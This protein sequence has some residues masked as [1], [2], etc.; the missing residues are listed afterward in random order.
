MRIDSAILSNA[1]ITA[2]S[3]NPIVSGSS[4]VN[5]TNTTG[6]STFS[7]SI[8]TYTDAKVAGLVDSAPGTLN[9]LNELAAALGDDANMSAS[10]ATTLGTKLPTATHTAFSSSN[11]SALRTEYSGA[12]TTLS[13]SAHSDRVAKINVLSGSAHTQR[14]AIDAKIS[15][16][17][18]TYATDASVSS[19][20]ASAHTRREQIS[21]SL[22]STIDG[23]DALGIST[24]TERGALSSSAHTQREAIKGLA[25]T[26]NNSLSSST[27]A[28]LRTEYKAGDTAL[29]ASA[30]TRRNELHALQLLSSSVGATINDNAVKLSGIESGATADQSNAEIRAAVEAAS[31]SNVFTDADHSK[32]NAIEASADVTDATNVA[33]AG[34]LMSSSLGGTINDNVVKLAGIEAGATADQTD[35]EIQDIVGAMLTGNTES[36]ITVTYQDGDGTIDFSVASQTDQNF[37]NADH[38]KLDGIEAGADVTDTTNVT[39]AGALMDSELTS[40]ADVKALDQSVIS[41]ADPTFGT[42]NMTDATNKRFMTDAQE[43]KLDSVETNADVT[44]ATNV[45]AAGALMDSEVTNLAAVKAIN[46]GLTTTSDVTFADIL[47]TGNLTVQGTRT[48]L[49]VATLNVEDLNITVASGSADSAA[50]DGAGITIAGADESLTWDHG[51]SRFNFSDDV[52]VVGNITVSGNVDGR[53]IA[54]DGTKLDG[55]EASADVTDATNVTAAGALMDSELTSIA[56]VKA[57]DQSVVA[58]A[59]PDFGTA[60]MSDASNKRFMTDAQET[61]LDGIEASADVTDATNVAAAGALMSSSLGATINDNAVKLSGIEAGATQDQT[62]SEIR[63]L[64]GTGNNGVVPSAGSAGEFLKHDGTFGTPSYTTNTDT[65]DMGDGFKVQ[66]SA[67]SDQFTITENEGLRFAGSGATSVSFDS[68]TQKVTI[69]STDN[70]TEYSVGDGGLTENNFTDALKTKL[71]GIATGATANTGDITQVSITAGT[72]LTG[73]LNTTSGNHVQTIDISR[74]TS[75]DWWGH[76]AYVE[77]DG[78]MEIGRYIDFHDSDSETDDYSVRLDGNSDTLAVSGH[79]TSTGNI[80]ATGDVTAYSD[81]TLKKDVKTIEGALDKTKELRGVEFTRIADDSKSIG[82]IAQE[83]EKVLPELV[84]TDDEGIKSVNYA[85]I[86]G[87]LIEAVKELSAKV[88]ELSK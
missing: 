47:V 73:T 53:D 72:G 81:E 75:G 82:V 23:L 52:H 46:Q 70:N 21:A 71:D 83:L 74:P 51:N 58:G 28:A 68:T 43:T 37:T 62:A 35:E 49:Q 3:E 20:S 59:S 88:E 31:D 1:I 86:T 48:E 19:L 2:S 30:H 85:Q 14:A 56:D 18:S 13:A 25:T 34:A 54:S 7:S 57:L 87:L 67:G 15:A 84:S 69:S 26:A 32:L 77:S 6:Y 16:L 76:T 42:A 12:D 8:Q 79:I 33:A 36:G 24:D 55:I 64:L 78:V 60:N 38:S 61:K 45:T 40:I 22:Q 50:A 17:D 10:F 66:N 9:T 44:D 63:T 27:A 80:T 65:V 41:G 11:A 5:I 39:A 4:Q 29:S